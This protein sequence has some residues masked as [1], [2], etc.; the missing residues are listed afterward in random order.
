M[1]SDVGLKDG[2]STGLMDLDGT[3]GAF[4]FATEGTSGDFK[5]H[6]TTS[7]P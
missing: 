2:A 4:V 7:F 6:I 5:G 1:P 3:E